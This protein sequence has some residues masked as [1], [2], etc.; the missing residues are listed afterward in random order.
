MKG[1]LILAGD[2]DDDSEENS[3]L[4]LPDS[5]LLP[6][7]MTLRG[8][9]IPVAVEQ[10]GDK[11][12]QQPECRSGSSKSRIRQ[13][14]VLSLVVL[15]ATSFA[16]WA[17][18]NARNEV[19]RLEKLVV[20]LEARLHSRDSIFTTHSVDSDAY[21]FENC[22]FK[23][24]LTAGSCSKDWM[25]WFKEYMFDHAANR[26]EDHEEKFM[27]QLLESMKAST[28]QSYSFVE[29]GF[30]NMTFERFNFAYLVRSSIDALNGINKHYDEEGYESS[31]ANLTESLVD[32]GSEVARVLLNS[33]S[34]WFR[35][36]YELVS[37]EDLVAW[38]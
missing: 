25:A 10:N 15:T 28:S 4:S 8:S 9:K 2:E 1:T 7:E 12:D 5:I 13:Y 32:K 38:N 27:R 21:E 19:H 29:D 31:L 36:V 16:L 30:K 35:T 6:S 34:S 33:S 14:L 24:E 3:Q 26:D 17:Y 37:E 22:Y 20:D 23:V 11:R 18:I